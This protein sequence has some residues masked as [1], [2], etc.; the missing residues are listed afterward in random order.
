MTIADVGST[1]AANAG[2]DTQQSRTSIAETFD[3]FLVLL[4]TQLQNQD[5][6]N[7]MET[8]E[9]TNQLV[10]FSQVEQAI[11]TNEK[12]DDLI[13]Q[14]TGSQLNEAAALVGQ[15]GEF[16][17]NAIQVDANG[18]F[19]TWAYNLP[20]QSAATGLS[21]INENGTV[22]RNL[23]GN[24]S[25]G[26]HNVNWDGR[27]NSGNPVPEGVYRLRIDAADSAGSPMGVTQTVVD[28]IRTASLDGF[29]A[30]LEI[31]PNAVPMSNLLAVREP[32]TAARNLIDNV[33]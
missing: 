15:Y 9:F 30:V 11:Q 10:S 20:Q 14:A 19:G 27:D 26:W 31:G 23:S 13:T 4:T 33:N 29:E 1:T 8:N 2:S 7:P 12:L 28:R 32:Q 22:I 17:G 3:T 18:D 5:P 16:E 24:T 21:I 25:A 6:I